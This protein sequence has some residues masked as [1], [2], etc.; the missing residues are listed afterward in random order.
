M[1]KTGGMKLWENRAIFRND[2]HPESKCF[3]L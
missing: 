2:P 1:L 3:L